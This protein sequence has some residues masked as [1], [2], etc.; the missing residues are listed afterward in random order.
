MATARVPVIADLKVTAPL[1]VVPMETDARKVIVARKAV[2]LKGT[3]DPRVSAVPMLVAPRVIAV[4]PIDLVVRVRIAVRNVI[5]S[6]R[7]MVKSRANENDP[8]TR[9]SSYFQHASFEI[10]RT[11]SSHFMTGAHVASQIIHAR[12][13]A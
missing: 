2:V 13:E 1:I 12:I 3:A 6:S 10:V 7:E 11:G 4:N 8:L 5:A 9:L